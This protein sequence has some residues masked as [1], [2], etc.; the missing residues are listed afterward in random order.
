VVRGPWPVVVTAGVPA[1]Q[2]LH[3]PGVLGL[4]PGHQG[5]NGKPVQAEDEEPRTTGDQYWE[6]SVG[7]DSPSVATCKPEMRFALSGA[8]PPRHSENCRALERELLPERLPSRRSALLFKTDGSWCSLS[9]SV[10]SYDRSRRSSRST[11]EHAASSA[12]RR[13]HARFSCRTRLDCVMVPANGD[14]R[15][16]GHD[17]RAGACHAA[18]TVCM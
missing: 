5:T 13:F 11:G 16:H 14:V 17:P 12:T 1:V 15:V 4:R 3:F 2:K 6:R 7:L 18:C 8:A 9:G 10:V